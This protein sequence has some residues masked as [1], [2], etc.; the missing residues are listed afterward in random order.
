MNKKIILKLDGRKMEFTND[1]SGY[2]HLMDYVS[3]ELKQRRPRK[4]K[5]VKFASVVP[6][7]EKVRE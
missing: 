3:R 2:Q 5:T 6:R 4:T 7:E 1:L